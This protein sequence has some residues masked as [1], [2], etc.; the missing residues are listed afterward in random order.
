MGRENR[1]NPLEDPVRRHEAGTV[2]SAN[3]PPLDPQREGPKE[4]KD[5]ARLKGRFKD[6]RGA[7]S[8]RDL[9]I[10]ALSGLVSGATV[11]V[12]QTLIDRVSADEPIP[13][14][15]PASRGIDPFGT[16]SFND[17]RLEGLPPHLQSIGQPRAEADTKKVNPSKTVENSNPNPIKPKKF[18]TP[19]PNREP[20]EDTSP[21]HMSIDQLSTVKEYT[22]EYSPDGT[23]NNFQ[24]VIGFI[25]EERSEPNI[26]RRVT[27]KGLEPVKTEFTR[28]AA[29][30]INGYTIGK[31]IQPDGDVF[32]AIYAPGK[33]G[34]SNQDDLDQRILSVEKITDDANEGKISGAIVW[35]KAENFKGYS[36]PFSFNSNWHESSTNEYDGSKNTNIPEELFKYI[37]IGG[38]PVRAVGLLQIPP[39]AEKLLVE[40]YQGKKNHLTYDEAQEKYLSIVNS[41]AA[42]VQKML[43]DAKTGGVSLREQL[44]TK[45]YVLQVN[46]VRFVPRD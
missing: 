33:N 15:T 24:P 44:E 41:N 31:E 3:F 2:F 28:Y 39:W 16:N 1:I 36:E 8:A 12:V 7:V 43:E 26:S 9:A 35:I 19:P 32:L 34:L 17:T 18:K 38:D 13:E 23:Y 30:G 14:P 29:V 46:N 10:G 42:T 27:S 45:R 4:N 6:Q 5:R 21:Q 37:G 11:V 25:L 22:A 20:S 40:N